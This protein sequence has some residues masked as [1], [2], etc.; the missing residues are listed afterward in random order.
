MFFSR[1]VTKYCDP[2]TKAGSVTGPSV[3][4][5]EFRSCPKPEAFL[6][7]ILPLNTAWPNY[8]NQVHISSHRTNAIM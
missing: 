1:S 4:V 2:V 6:S 3:V 8:L 5:S 7:D